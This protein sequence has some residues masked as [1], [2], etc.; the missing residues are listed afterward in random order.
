MKWYN[1]RTLLVNFSTALIDAGV[2]E[3]TDEVKDYFARPYRYDEY[4]DAWRE[5]KY[6]MEDDEGWDDF[7]N[8]IDNEPDEEENDEEETEE[9][10]EEEEEEDNDE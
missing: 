8:S 1:D 3:D 7:V 5:A 10:E 2:L 4:F 9:E 6:P